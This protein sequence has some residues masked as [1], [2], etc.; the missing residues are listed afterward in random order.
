MN[1][2]PGLLG[3]AVALAVMLAASAWAWQQLPADA[4]V[5]VHWGPD[6]SPDRYGGKVLGL[7]G[8]PA[9][10]GGVALLLAVV[11]SLEPRAEHLARSQR[12]YTLTWVATMAFLAVVHLVAVVG[13]VGLDAPVTSLVVV[14]AGVLLAVIG[15]ALRRVRSTYT[16]GIRTP[17]TLDSERAW[18]RTHA[19]GGVL[20]VVVGVATAVAGA[21]AA[22]PVQVAVLVGG[23][24]AVLLAVLV[25][26]Y[27][28]W[29][30][31]PDRRGDPGV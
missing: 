28:A 15:V 30:A 3:S 29:R 2:R 27:L 13:A 12:A 22:P 16:F 9:V 4:S 23:L 26:S 21:L 20:L 6:G 17:W 19:L 25:V 5:P 18:E 8:L 31:D 1:R 24:A 7:L 11:P 14:A 10:A